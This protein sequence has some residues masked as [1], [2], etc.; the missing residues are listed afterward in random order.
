MV[1]DAKIVIIGGT[2]PFGKAVARTAVQQGGRVILAGRDEEA[3]DRMVRELGPG[4]SRCIFDVRDTRS[5]DYCLENISPF[6]HLLI[7]PEEAYFAPFLEM[8]LEEARRDFEANFWGPVA[9]VQEAAACIREAGSITIITSALP[10]QPTLN[11]F[12]SAATAGAVANVVL[13]LSRELR[14]VRV[15]AFACEPCFL[16]DGLPGKGSHPAM[17]QAANELLALLADGGRTGSCLSFQHG[18]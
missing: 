8:D 7:L 17:A 13:T 2:S 16:Q 4:L 10:G 1:K 18:T 5:M 14:P 12:T 15:N 11:R 6:D 9:A 3:I